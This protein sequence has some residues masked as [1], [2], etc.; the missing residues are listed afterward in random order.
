MNREYTEH[1]QRSFRKAPLQIQSAFDKQADLL[2]RNLSHP[3]LRAKKFNES[4]D[5][6]QARVTGSW[7]MYFKIQGDTYIFLDIIP[8]PK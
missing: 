6:W 2:L 7:R 4:S 8:H 5:V 3:S 1:F